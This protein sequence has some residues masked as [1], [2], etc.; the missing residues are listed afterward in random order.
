MTIRE[1]T[2]VRLLTSQS[3]PRRFQQDLVEHR[4]QRDPEGQPWDG[5]GGGGKGG[6]A[7]N[8]THRMALRTPANTRR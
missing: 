7:A 1:G 8:T 5:G 6:G 3:G 2:I 4:N